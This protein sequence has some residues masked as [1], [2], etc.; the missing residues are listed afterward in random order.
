M[1]EIIKIYSIVVKPEY[2]GR[3]VG[4]KMFQRVLEIASEGNIKKVIVALVP[5]SVE[6]F[7]KAQ[8]LKRCK[9][10]RK[11]RLEDA[12]DWEMSIEKDV[13]SSVSRPYIEEIKEVEKNG[14]D[15]IILI[16]WYDK[17]TGYV[18]SRCRFWFAKE[19]S[20]NG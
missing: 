20:D 5:V 8:G 9:E 13:K 12:Y 2:R 14:E 11:Y 10:K 1:G 18:I 16:S 4:S 6:S 15:Q 3:D 19:V 17:E 7:Y